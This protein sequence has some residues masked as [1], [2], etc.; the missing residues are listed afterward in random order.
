[1]ITVLMTSYQ[2]FMQ[3]PKPDSS[4]GSSKFSV[5]NIIHRVYLEITY[6]YVSFAWNL[7]KLLSC[8]APKLCAK[9]IRH[10][11]FEMKLYWAIHL[12]FYL[13]EPKTP[14]G[15]WKCDKCNNINYPFRTKC[16][17]PTCGEEKPLQAN[18]PDDLATDQDNQVCDSDRILWSLIF[19]MPYRKLL[20]VC[21]KFSIQ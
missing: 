9:F 18:S 2:L 21:L 3:G 20:A 6:I 15:S 11:F 19:T 12:T 7:G 1:M 13:T 16:N 10:N 14:E 17:R 8:Y 4:R 5:F